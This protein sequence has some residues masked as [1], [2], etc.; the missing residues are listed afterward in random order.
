MN[1]KPSKRQIII[2]SIF[3]LFLFLNPSMKEFHEHTGDSYSSLSRKMNFLILSIYEDSGDYYI[4]FL[5]NFI[6]LS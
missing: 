3:L 6:K 5:A 2:A 1:F 4:G